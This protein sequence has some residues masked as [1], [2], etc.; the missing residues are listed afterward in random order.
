MHVR[1]LSSPFCKASTLLGHITVSLL[2]YSEV[3]TSLPFTLLAYIPRVF[4]STVAFM[5]LACGFHGH[6]A[7]TFR[8]SK[9]SEQ[10]WSRE[11]SLDKHKKSGCIKLQPA[12]SDDGLAV[13]PVDEN[14]AAFMF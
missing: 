6:T 9:N 11:E 8:R 7:Q 5:R 2:V 3:N 10:N 1:C 14:R 12:W 4:A 13:C